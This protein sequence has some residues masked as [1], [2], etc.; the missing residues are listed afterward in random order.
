MSN[1]DQTNTGAIF[2]N[3]KG[4]NPKR[5]DYRGEVNAGGATFKLSGWIKTAKT[6]KRAGQTF[7]SVRLEPSSQPK[8]APAPSS[9]PPPAPSGDD[10][11]PF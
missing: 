3:D 9:A 11:V 6:G 10:D 2:R 5:P 1:Y 4:D 8:Q 7:I